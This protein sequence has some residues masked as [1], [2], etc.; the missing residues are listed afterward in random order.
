GNSATDGGG[1]AVV[2][3]FNF[4][5]WNSVFCDNTA[6]N[7]G[8]AISGGPFAVLDHVTFSNNSAPTEP[9]Y[10]PGLI[11]AYNSLFWKGDTS[12][13]TLGPD[14]GNVIVPDGEDPFVA[15]SDPAGADG[16]F[17]TSPD[18]FELSGSVTTP[19][20][21]ATSPSIL[22]NDILGNPHGAS[23]DAG[24]YEFVN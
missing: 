2:G 10:T 11:S 4:D 22:Q 20:G 3:G 15:S 5:M 12:G 1:M 23:A 14:R 13:L 24:A 6:S 16:V 19:I 7:S 17:L 9:V 18:G 21:A 8:G